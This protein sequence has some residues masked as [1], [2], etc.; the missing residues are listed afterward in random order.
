MLAN[1]HTLLHESAENFGLRLTA[2]WCMAMQAA[3]RRRDGY[4]RPIGLFEAIAVMKRSAAARPVRLTCDS[5]VSSGPRCRRVGLPP[6]RRLRRW[7][8]ADDPPDEPSGPIPAELTGRHA[9]H[10]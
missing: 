10:A 2:A 4:A 8:Q 9:T 7:D 5:N 6:T 1:A 3:G